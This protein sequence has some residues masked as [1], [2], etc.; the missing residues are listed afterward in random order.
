MTM[1]TAL[2]FIIVA[3]IAIIF[4]LEKTARELSTIRRLIAK[5]LLRRNYPG[6]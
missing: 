3:L 2:V 6:E 5:E 4:F 1:E